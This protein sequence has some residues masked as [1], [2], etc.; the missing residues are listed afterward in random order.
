MDCVMLG[1]LGVWVGG[2][3]VVPSAPK[4][5]QV[6]GLLAVHRDRVVSVG[7]LA[8]ELW[9]EV[10]PRSSRATV[11]TYVLQVRELI[12]TALERGT[13]EANGGGDCHAKDVLLTVPGGYV[14]RSGGGGCDVGE[15]ERMAGSGYRAM[16]AGDCA[17][18][19]AL[20]RRALG[21]WSGPA[22]AGVRAGT[23][24]QGEVRRLE[25]AR[26]CALE[27]RIEADLQ[28]GR[29]RELLAEL[30]VLVSRYP[31]HEGLC[32][33]FMVALYRAG[34]RGEALEAY[35]RLR[36]VLVRELGLEPSATLV[37]LQHSILV[38]RPERAVAGSAA[39]GGG[40]GDQGAER[41][42][43]VG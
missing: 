21:L 27:R 43:P 40:T 17:G 30:T 4:P 19:A 26:L 42:A 5:R 3:S 20:L 36:A 29:H 23:H 37:K 12:G 6:L 39:R 32:G 9:G 13:R 1:S 22:L 2:M 14:L 31:L 35:H 25:E 24:L 11:Q 41:F 18:A 8:E 34:R 33:Q 38:A 15:F 16:D 28:L 10:L 7:T